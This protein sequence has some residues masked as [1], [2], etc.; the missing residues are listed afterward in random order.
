MAFPPQDLACPDPPHCPVVSPV[1]LPA[2]LPIVRVPQ[3]TPL[4]R[5]YD[6]TWGYDEP[7]P[8]FGDTR[9]A[10]FDTLS[11]TR[12]PVMYAGETDTAALLETV[13]HAV[14]QSA[15]R[16]IKE[17]HLRKQLLVHL[18]VPADLH[19]V[20]LRDEVLTDA[21]IGRDQLV[22][23]PSEHY[24]CT[25]LIAQHLHTV[26]V[27]TGLAQGLVWHSR[28]AELA[29][30]PPAVVLMVFSNAYGVARG[31]WQRIG[32]GTRNLLEGPGRL[33]VDEIATELDATIDVD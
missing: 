21:G 14:H 13:F 2:P 5:V 33:R 18:A 22:S 1:V 16:W 9:F 25:R 23:T 10:P 27:E 17:S 26:Y 11:G 8:G 29:R 28:Q 4:Y 3:G 19:L 7:N 6:S 32:P 31:G 30:R 12:V 15:P 24:P 20:D